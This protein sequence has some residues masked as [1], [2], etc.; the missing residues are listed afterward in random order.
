MCWKNCIVN[1]KSD[2]NR[3]DIDKLETTSVDISK[4]NNIVKN[5]VKKTAQMDQLKE[6]IQLFQRDKIEDF[7]KKIP[8]NSKFFVNQEFNRLTKICFNARMSEVSNYL[9]TKKEAENTFNLRNKNGEKTL[10][11]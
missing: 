8:G 5:N 10:N 9:V 2:V 1:I 6:L 11:V 3:L 4:L 7:N